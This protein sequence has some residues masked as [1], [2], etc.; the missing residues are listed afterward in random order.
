VG[1]LLLDG[2]QTYRNDVTALNRPCVLA[3]SDCLGEEPFFF[4]MSLKRKA[5][6]AALSVLLEDDAV[7]VVDKPAGTLFFDGE[8]QQGAR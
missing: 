2:E 8:G 6:E 1:T 4:A 3:V 5:G 7:I